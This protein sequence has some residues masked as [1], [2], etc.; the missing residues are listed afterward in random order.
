[1]TMMIDCSD[2]AS[3]PEAVLYA[4][5][6]ASPQRAVVRD[7]EVGGYA[8]LVREVPSDVVEGGEWRYGRSFPTLQE[9]SSPDA[10]DA[11]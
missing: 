6:A 5:L 2:L 10:W 9:A 1:M 7:R 4:V 8:L 3:G 11:F